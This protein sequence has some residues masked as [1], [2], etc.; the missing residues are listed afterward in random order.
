MLQ[1]G[2]YP[3]DKIRGYQM[4]RS[5]MEPDTSIR[6]YFFANLFTKLKQQTHKAIVL[7]NESV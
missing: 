3:G 5:E 1:P 6:D 2:Q 7:Q 4:C